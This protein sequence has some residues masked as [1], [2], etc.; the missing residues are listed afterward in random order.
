MLTS[1]K[2]WRNLL[3]KVIPIW[4]ISVL[5]VFG[6]M[7]AGCSKDTGT[8][9]KT[10]ANTKWAFTQS[11]D[12]DA[13]LLGVNFDPTT[14]DGNGGKGHSGQGNGILDA[15]EMA[16]IAHVLNDEN[17]DL[18]ASNGV[19]HSEVMAA[20]RQA[21]SSAQNDLKPLAERFP[22]AAE[23][24]VGY[25]MIG[26][27]ESY[28]TIKHMTAM[29]GG[30]MDGDY[31]LTLTLGKYFG[32]AGDADGDGATNLSEYNAFFGDGRDA[33]VKAAL[34]PNIKPSAD[35][36]TDDLTPIDRPKEDIKTVGIIL[37]PG[38]EVLD[39]YGPLEMWGYVREFNIIMVAEKTGPVISAQGAATVADFSFENAPK[40]DIIMVPGGVGT[41]PELENPA[42]IDFI[43]S[44]DQ[45]TELT[46]SVCT[47]AALL[48]KAGLLDGHK[49]TTNKR[50]F[51]IAEKQGNNVN[52]IEDARWVSDGKYIT[53]SGV[54]AGTDMA[55]GLVEQLY[56][57]KRAAAIAS[58]VEYEWHDDPTDDPFTEFTRR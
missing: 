57:K 46:T 14:T 50:F 33:Y 32:P 16:L 27:Q 22:T 11:I 54:S 23:M 7:V 18:S 41:T 26:T 15:A 43:R 19:Q 3:A 35:Q 38:F 42:M 55:L 40:L 45:Q 31:S 37:Y 1:T 6:F 48:A 12:F 10:D 51:F 56:G 17:F 39:V 13:A 47:G 29:F 25:A 8:E 34:N 24:T 58:S 20:Y 44:R 53:S 2:Q 9:S 52:W 36:N 21:L 30:V 28:D 4:I 5:I 49:A